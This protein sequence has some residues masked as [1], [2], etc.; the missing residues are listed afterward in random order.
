[1]SASL[2]LDLAG[3]PI[4]TA[5]ADV[6]AV[7]FFREDRPLRGDAGRADWRLCGRLSRLLMEG[8]LDD[9]GALLLTTE[10]HLRAPLLLGLGLGPAGVH[11][12]EGARRASRELVE[13]VLR[14]RLC[15][16]AASPPGLWLGTLP[17]ERAL[18]ALLL[19]VAAALAERPTALRLCIA[20]VEPG[21]ME[22]PGVRGILAR[23]DASGLDVRLRLPAARP[24]PTA[25]PRVA[26]RPSGEE[27][28]RYASAETPG[29]T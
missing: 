10:G 13:R 29:A 20:D 26:P 1:M 19:G 3:A 25:P 8:H 21:Q 12:F 5:R 16:L 22:A 27:G 14:L 6:A 23:L 15:S 28:T 2:L 4:E 11:G 7:T 18:E 24:V 9:E 17:P